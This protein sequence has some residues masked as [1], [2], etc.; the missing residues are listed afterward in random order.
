LFEGFRRRPED[1]DVRNAM[2]NYAYALLRAGLARGLAAQGFH[3]A[4]GLHHDSV[5]NAFNLADDLIEPWR[6]LADLH[7][8]RYVAERPAGD[9]LT[10]DDRRELAR[11]LVADVRVGTEA[12]SVTTAIELQVD[13]LVT[14]L[15]TKNPARLPVPEPV[16]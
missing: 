3:P 8:A 16:G 9:T 7:V 11:L 6:P 5:D 4:I 2:L 10:V 13:G 14:A 12:M 1:D 15:D